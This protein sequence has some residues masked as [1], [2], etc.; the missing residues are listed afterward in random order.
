MNTAQLIHCA[1][2]DRLLSKYFDGVFASDTL[3]KR[4]PGCYIFNTDPIS[5][6]GSHWQAR[7]IESDGSI[8]HFDSYGRA[9]QTT[10]Y[11]STRI[12]GPLSSSCGQYCLY[13]LCHKV[14]GRGMKEIVNDFSTDYVLNDLCITEFINR[15][16]DLATETYHLPRVISQ[17]CKSEN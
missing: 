8:E 4:S 11:N 13:Y 10:S 2:Q 14:R 3:P 7:F 1:K 17:I 5:K 15:H 6:P 12:Q 16:F 9:A